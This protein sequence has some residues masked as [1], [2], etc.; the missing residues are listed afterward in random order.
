MHWVEG[1]EKVLLESWVGLEEEE[2][3]GS[4]VWAEVEVCEQGGLSLAKP[5]YELGEVAI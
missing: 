1:V 4:L 5:C 2:V 3:W